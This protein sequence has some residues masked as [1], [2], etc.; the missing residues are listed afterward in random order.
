MGHDTSSKQ[1]NI[2]VCITVSNSL[3]SPECL[4]EAME[5]RKK[6]PLLLL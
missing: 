1:H 6:S 5:T 2:W 4:D 3:N